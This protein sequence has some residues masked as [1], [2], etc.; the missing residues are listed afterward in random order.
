MLEYKAIVLVIILAPG[1]EASGKWRTKCGV[2]GIDGV[3]RWSA[4]PTQRPNVVSR[5]LKKKKKKKKNPTK[6][7]RN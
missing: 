4:W 2:I 1:L 5:I 6:K 3:P 7:K